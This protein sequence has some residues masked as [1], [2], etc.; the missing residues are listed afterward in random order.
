MGRCRNVRQL[1]PCAEPQ[2][3]GSCAEHL[4]GTNTGSTLPAFIRLLNSW[5]QNR[6]LLAASQLCRTG[7]IGQHARWQHAEL[8]H[9]LGRRCSNTKCRSWERPKSKTPC[10]RCASSGTPVSFLQG[11]GRLRLNS[12]IVATAPF[13]HRRCRGFCSR[14]AASRQGMGSE[15]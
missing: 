7:E 1:Q 6:E 15:W 14:A 2:L 10:P 8:L 5:L 9:M 13:G 3:L 11:P 12:G 4:V